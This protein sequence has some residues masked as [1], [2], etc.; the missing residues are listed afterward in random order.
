MVT[1]VSIE[2]ILKIAVDVSSFGN[3]ENSFD[4]VRNIFQKFLK[5]CPTSCYMPIINS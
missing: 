4:Q 3:I 5:K 2:W 1:A